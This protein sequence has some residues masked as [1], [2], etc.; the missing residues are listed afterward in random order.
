MTATW[1]AAPFLAGGIAATALMLV[2]AAAISPLA[3]L[4]LVP[5]MAAGALV[6][7]RPFAGLMLL[8]VLAQLD[9]VANVVSQALPISAYKLLTGLTLAGVMLRWSSLERSRRLGPDPLPMRATV[10]FGLWMLVSFLFSVHRG[11]GQEDLVGFLSVMVLFYLVLVL[12]DRE[13]KLESLVW[14]LIAAGLVSA[15]LVLLDT[16]LGVRLLSTSVAATTAE[17]EGHAR[18]AG[19]SD[20]N[21]TTAAHMLLA[22]T[23]LAGVMAVEC[24]RFRLVGLAAALVGTAALVLTFA[25]SASITY[26]VTLLVFVVANR[27]HRLFPLWIMLGLIAVTAALPLVP[28]SYWERMGTLFDFNADRT[29]WRRLSYNLIGLELAAE[30]PVFGVGPGNFPHYYV[31]P[32]F[33]WYPG[34]VLEPRQLHNSYLEVAVETGLVGLACFLAVMLS[35][36]GMGVAAARRGAATLRPAASALAYAFFAFL[37]ASAFMPNEDNKFMW[38]LAGLCC[39]AGLLMRRSTAAEGAGEAPTPREPDGTSSR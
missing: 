32:E 16:L 5:A 10:L 35:S 15:V 7:L 8:A 21:P 26:A 4:A 1:L 18:S 17:W 3:A 28:E 23:V 27:R 38:L 2:I 29:L 30:H 39:A 11:P 19:A 13:E 25:R 33:R 34:R 9:A 31:G 22:S 12:V 20:Y 6:V 36:L 37:I 14:G 24:R